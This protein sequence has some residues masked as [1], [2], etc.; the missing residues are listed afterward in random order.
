M[1]V[2]KSKAPCFVCKKTEKTVKAK[3]SFGEIVL[4]WDHAYEHVGEEPPKK[5]TKKKDGKVL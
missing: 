3:G 2:F 1:K 4:C 5:T